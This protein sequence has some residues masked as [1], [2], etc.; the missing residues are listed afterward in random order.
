MVNVLKFTHTHSQIYITTKFKRQLYYFG[1]RKPSFLKMQKNRCQFKNRKHFYDRN[2]QIIK[3]KIT[4]IAWG[5]DLGL[6]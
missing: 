2:N 6:M 1:M 5:G 4:K 3:V